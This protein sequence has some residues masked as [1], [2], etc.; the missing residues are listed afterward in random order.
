MVSVIDETCD[1]IAELIRK[2]FGSTPKRKD[3]HGAFLDWVH[4]RARRIP[5]RPRQVILSTEVRSKVS[6]YPTI[7]R[8]SSA[9]RAGED[10]SAWLSRKITSHMRSPRA[11]MMFN[12]WQIT[13]FHLGRVFT[14]PNT[15]SGTDDLLYVHVAAEYATFLDVLPHRSWT[16]QDLL[17]ILLETRPAA[18]EPVEVKNVTGQTLTDEALLAF[19]TNNTNVAIAVSGR[20][21]MG[22]GILSS[23][24][25]IRLRLFCTCIRRDILHLKETIEQGTIERPTASLIAHQI[26]VPVRLGILFDTAGVFT[27]FDK[28]RQ[29]T[30]FQSLVIE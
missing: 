24:H 27:I 8:I 14:R 5:C 28:T 15:V 6:T 19:R 16:A 21:F 13:H 17:R 10:V 20:A 29:I 7:S 23:G 25:A 11:D 22:G 26:G 12:D 1:D 4:Y 9:L 18:M 3:L 2:D 30:F